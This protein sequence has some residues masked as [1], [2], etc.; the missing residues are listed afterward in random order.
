LDATQEIELRGCDLRSALESVTLVND[1]QKSEQFINMPKRMTDGRF[2][3]KM[4]LSLPVQDYL[5]YVRVYPVNFSD[6]YNECLNEIVYIY[7]EP[8][9][10]TLNDVNIN[11]MDISWISNINSTIFSALEYKDVATEKWQTTDYIKMNY[12]KE[13]IYYIKNL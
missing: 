11:S 3:T 2:F 12:N 8:N 9:D 7:S 13:V 4:N 10:I 1:T 6:F 5:I